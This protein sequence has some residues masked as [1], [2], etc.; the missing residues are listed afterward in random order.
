MERNPIDSDEFR[1]EWNNLLD[2][3][4]PGVL[5]REKYEESTGKS[6]GKGGTKK[7]GQGEDV[8]TVPEDLERTSTV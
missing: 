1:K 5:N 8:G 3:N 7:K 2:L 6:K 4:V